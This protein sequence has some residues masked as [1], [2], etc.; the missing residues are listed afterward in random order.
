MHA[1][2]VRLRWFHEGQ[3]TE[4]LRQVSGYWERYDFYIVTFLLPFFNVARHSDCS[5][6][7][8][9][10]DIVIK[11]KHHRRCS[12]S[13]CL[14]RLRALRWILE[15]E[16]LEREKPIVQGGCG[17]IG[18]KSLLS[19]WLLV[20]WRSFCVNTTWWFVLSSTHWSFT[21]TVSFTWSINSI[22]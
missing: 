8:C 18:Y 19:S 1:S 10:R 15:C 9:R 16:K 12:L 14:K 11:K 7:E 20:A 2:R 5:V 6:Y 22:L 13:H 3:Y 17:P 21:N 4:T